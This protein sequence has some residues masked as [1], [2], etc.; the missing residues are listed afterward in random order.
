MMTVTVYIHNSSHNTLPFQLETPNDPVY[1]EV[2]AVDLNDVMKDSAQ[3][4]VSQ[5]GKFHHQK[6]QKGL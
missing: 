1:L 2:G 4:E 3:E 6:S 5:V